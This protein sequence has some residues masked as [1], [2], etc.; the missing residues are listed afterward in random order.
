MHKIDNSYKVSVFSLKTII[1]FLWYLHDFEA[2][3]SQLYPC[4]ASM[5]NTRGWKKKKGTFFVSA[6]GGQVGQLLQRVCIAPV[7]AT[8]KRKHAVSDGSI[9]ISSELMLVAQILG[10]KCFKRLPLPI[11]TLRARC[12]L[13]WPHEQR[14]IIS[15]TW[16]LTSHPTPP[17]PMFD[18][19]KHIPRGRTLGVRKNYF[20]QHA[21]NCVY[22]NVF[23]RHCLKKQ[24]GCLIP[25]R[26]KKTS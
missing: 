6:R 17:Q 25:R 7:C 8:N 26:T 4:L 24:C 9:H 2:M 19:N 13:A 1:H 11:Y 21:E 10:Y 15:V 18:K 22:T 12:L 16:T 3:N 5:C 20:L 14:N 23:S